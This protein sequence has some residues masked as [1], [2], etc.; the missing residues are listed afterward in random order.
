MFTG[1]QIRDKRKLE[2]LSV[3]ALALKIGVEEDNLYK[4]EKGT[5]PSNPEDYLKV[6]KWLENVPRENGKV[7]AVSDFKAHGSGDQDYR[8]KYIDSLERENKRLQKDLDASLGDLLENALLA[9]S[10]A[11]TNQD[12]LIEILSKQRKA[13]VDDISGEVGKANIA[14]YKILKGGRRDGVSK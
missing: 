14:K 8:E 10:V 2:G 12:L 1:K 5:K 9:R 4:W 3:K 11:E 13:S 7:V 6:S